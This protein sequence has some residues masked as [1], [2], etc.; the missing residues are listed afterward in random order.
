MEDGPL[1]KK[2]KGGQQQRL[3]AHRQ[4][5]EA[6]APTKDQQCLL[7]EWLK[8][9]WAWGQMSPQTV[10]H[11]ASLA[12]KDML[13]AGVENVPAS[14]QQLARLGTSGAFPNNC[15]RDLMAVVSRVSKL[16]P[17]LQVLMPLKVKGGSRLLGKL[18]L[19]YWQSWLGCFLAEIRKPSIYGW[20][21]AEIPGL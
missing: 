2:R 20:P 13:S 12:K 6:A 9:Q 1:L 4:E 3:Q 18:F 5:M 14:L 17:P 19:A 10:Q 16:P 8:E 15:H 11:V 7:A 21:L